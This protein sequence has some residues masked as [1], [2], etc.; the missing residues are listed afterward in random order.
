LIQT[1]K[2][3]SQDHLLAISRRYSIGEALTD[4]LV[5]RGD[6]NV[7]LSTAGNPGAKFSDFGF[8]TLVKRSENDVDLGLKV[9]ARHD[10]PRQHLLQLFA[11]SSEAVRRKIQSGDRRNADLVRELISEASDQLQ[12]KSRESS[13]K[14]SAARGQVD[15]LRRKGD[16]DEAHLYE[17]ARTGKFDETAIM[18]SMMCGLPIGV[19]ER[20]IVHKNPEQA[21]VITKA[22]G[23]TWNTAKAILSIRAGAKGMAAHD[24]AQS[25]AS[26]N[27]LKQET[28]EK[29][30][31]FYRLRERAR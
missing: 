2:T 13:A 28:A 10:I 31:R 4:V 8:S 7:V 15:A 18:L 21:I 6:Q 9:W 19:V 24:L 27:K 11:E 1:A 23:L 3:K 14:Y 22:V 30:I 26:F 25:L 12:S 29:A 16:I 5:E 20:A 17:F